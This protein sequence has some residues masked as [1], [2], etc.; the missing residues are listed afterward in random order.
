VVV[1]PSSPEAVAANWDATRLDLTVDAVRTHLDGLD[2][3]ERLLR[4][5]VAALGAGKHLLLVGPPGTGKT[6]LARA[7]ARAAAADDYIAGLFTSTA[8][9]DWTTFD[10][11]GGYTLARDGRLSFR[12]G[13]FLRALEERRWLLVDELNRADVDRAFGELMTVLAGGG[14]DTAFELDDG[15]LV[16]LGAGSDRSHPVPATFRVLATM[17]TWDKTSLFR[18]S[19]AVQRRFAIVHVGAPPAAVY[20]RLIAREANRS[21]ESLD[22]A[23][24]SALQGLFGDRGILSVRPVGPAVALDMTRYVR[25]RAGGAD[26]LAEAVS[27]YL[28][29]QLEGL[30]APDARAAWQVI[31]AAVGPDVS[32]DAAD[33]LRARWSDLFPEVGT[34]RP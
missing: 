3:P 33:E 31:S 24:R 26:G 6:E 32:D 20:A 18:L 21:G 4:Q 7:L 28:L 9:A 17:N 30:G 1:L 13:V 5:C 15:S 10:T 2:V 19:Y 34:A 8:S 23:S 22:P 29:A 25:T 11:I 14:A 16:R 27:M 12:P